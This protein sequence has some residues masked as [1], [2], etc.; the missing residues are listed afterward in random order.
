MEKGKPGQKGA[1][2]PRPGTEQ[3]RSGTHIQKGESE[4]MQVP[5]QGEQLKP[6]QE[7][8]KSSKKPGGTGS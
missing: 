6:K 1:G 2:K 7:Q 4:R 5:K 3:V 8:G